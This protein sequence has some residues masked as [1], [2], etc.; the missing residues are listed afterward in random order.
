MVVT[1]TVGLRVGIYLYFLTLSL[2]GYMGWLLQISQDIQIGWEFI[3]LFSDSLSTWIHGV[4]NNWFCQTFKWGGKFTNIFN[5]SLP[6]Y[7][8]G[9]EI[10]NFTIQYIQIGLEFINIFWHFLYMGWEIT[11]FARHPN[12]VVIYLHPV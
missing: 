8:M 6:L 1:L 9:R 2:S 7:Y 5:I 4:G 3:H 10:T 12:G 11:V